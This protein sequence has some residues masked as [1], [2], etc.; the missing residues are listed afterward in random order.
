MANSPISRPTRVAQELKRTL[1][2]LI[3]QEVK[4][5]RFQKMTITDC[6]ISKDLSVAKVHFSLIG[7]NSKDPEV[8]ETLKA[9]E[10]AKGFF[11]SEI[12]NRLKL[13]IVPDLRFYFDTVPEN[14]QHI[15]DLINKALNKN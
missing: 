14:V 9:L 5:P 12:G 4:D 15:E 3:V 11:R 6:Q 13:R 1:A 2:Q 8:E 10:K 7:H